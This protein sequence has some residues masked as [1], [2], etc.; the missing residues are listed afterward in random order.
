MADVMSEMM[1]KDM[2]NSLKAIADTLARMERLLGQINDRVGN[3]ENQK[4]R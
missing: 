4:K 3:I 1:A 2:A